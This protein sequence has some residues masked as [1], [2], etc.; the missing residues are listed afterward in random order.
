MG[1]MDAYKRLEK[2]CGDVMDDSRKVTA[3]I[4]EM[5]ET[6]RGEYYVRGWDE[7]LRKLKHYRWVRNQIAH[8]EGCT[9]QNMCTAEDEAWIKNFYTRIMNQNDPISLY[10]RAK[11][12]NEAATAR[13]NEPVRKTNHQ[14]KKKSGRKLAAIILLAVAVIIFALLIFL[15]AEI[16]REVSWGVANAAFPS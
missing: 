3:Y 5:I 7:D 14:V 2:L 12:K 11:R 10:Y 13:V 4:D 1:F 6:P 15:V 9:E 8:E 16:L